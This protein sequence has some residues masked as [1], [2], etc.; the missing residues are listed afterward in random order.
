MRVQ[1]CI[2][3]N[4]TEVK[5]HRNVRDAQGVVLHFIRYGRWSTKEVWW[6]IVVSVPDFIDRLCPGS[7]HG[8]GP[9]HMQ[10]GLRG[11]ADLHYNTVNI[12]WQNLG[13]CGL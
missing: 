11:A 6:S 8:P 5:I 13:L 1:L 2:H 3:H 4:Y 10:Y 7:N 12:I 9:S